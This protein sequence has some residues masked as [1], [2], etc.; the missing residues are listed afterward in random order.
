M[1][2]GNDVAADPQSLGRIYH[3]ALRPS[4][5]SF[6]TADITKRREKEGECKT[7][8]YT[9][10]AGRR[11][12]GGRVMRR[13]HEEQ[14]RCQMGVK[15]GEDAGFV[16]GGALLFPGSLW[17]PANHRAARH[18]MRASGERRKQIHIVNKDV[19]NQ[20]TQ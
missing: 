15:S 10:D 14:N 6:F 8:Q 5:E 9:T 1:V 18:S 3:S 17:Q 4:C 19:R 20:L 13:K 7:K 2:Y 12:T 11:N 16:R